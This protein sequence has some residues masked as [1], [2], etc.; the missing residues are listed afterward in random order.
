MMEPCGN[1]EILADYRQH[2]AGEREVVNWDRAG[3][4]Y[5]DIPVVYLKEVTEDRYRVDFPLVEL[6][7]SPCYFWEVSID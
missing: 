6:H 2:Y 1:R 4:T 5:F 7:C 3:V